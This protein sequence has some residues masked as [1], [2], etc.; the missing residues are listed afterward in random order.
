MNMDSATR[1]FI[2]EKA[3]RIES[4]L[5]AAG[6]QG[7]G[8]NA[9]RLSV[10]A[11]IPAKIN[12]D[13]SSVTTVRNKASHE[14]SFII[15]KDE[16]EKYVA[17]A[18]RAIFHLE[19]VATQSVRLL[20]DQAAATEKPDPQTHKQNPENNT[21]PAVSAGAKP[22]RDSALVCQSPADPA[23]PAWTPPAIDYSSPKFMDPDT[24]RER[25]EK[26]L[27]ENKAKRPPQ[28]ERLVKVK[29]KGLSKETKEK[30]WTGLLFVGAAIVSDAF[31]K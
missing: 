22:A 15:S 26:L 18:D 13:I 31:R 27:A 23:P 12:R 11:S 21:S 8:L 19:F 6:A 14:D 16:L 30:L 4:L 1:G 28:E 5:K 17:A 24:R 25:M 10:R 20:A 2:L 3:L 7:T 29:K 9:L